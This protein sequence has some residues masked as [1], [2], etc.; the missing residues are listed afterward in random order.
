MHYETKQNQ[1]LYTVH[2]IPC[3]QQTSKH[4][5]EKQKQKSR[6]ISDSK[7]KSHHPNHSSCHNTSNDSDSVMIM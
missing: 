4:S 1:L 5:E 6:Q 7:Q 3:D 2:N